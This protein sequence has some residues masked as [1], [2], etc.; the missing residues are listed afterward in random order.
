MTEV[1]IGDKVRIHYAGTLEDGSQFDS[2]EGREPLE[3]VVGSG[4]IIRGLDKAM[5]G[6]ETGEFKTVFVPSDEAY[7]P[8]D[9]NALQDI[10]L[11]QI[12]PEIPLAIGTVLQMSNQDGDAIAVTVVEVTGDTV[13]LDAN[14]ALAGKDLTFEIEL[15]SI[16]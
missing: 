8:R 12:P 7:G 4:Q 14:H 13:T 11:E 6:M 2:S 9:P 3:F 16:D 5:P 15:V 1:K 10:P